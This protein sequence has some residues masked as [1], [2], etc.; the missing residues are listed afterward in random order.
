MKTFVV[1][2]AVTAMLLFVLSMLCPLALLLWLVWIPT[3]IIGSLVCCAVWICNT[4]YNRHVRRKQNGQSVLYDI[5]CSIGKSKVSIKR[6]I[7]DGSQ[8]ELE[9]LNA[10]P[11]DEFKVFD[12]NNVIKQANSLM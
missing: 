5:G 6:G 11:V 1:F 9:R 4:V 10:E 12:H 2:M 7:A 3:A 8:E